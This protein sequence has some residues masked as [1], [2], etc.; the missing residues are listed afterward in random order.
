MVSYLPAKP[1]LFSLEGTP[2][3]PDY[4]ALKG[5]R[6]KCGYVFFPRQRYGCERCG[7]FGHDIE[8]IE[9]SGKGKLRAFAT[10]HRSDSENYQAPYIAATIVL[11]AGCAI[12]ALLDVADESSLFIGQTVYSTLTVVDC[13]ERGRKIAD[14]RFTPVP[15]DVEGSAGRRG[16]TS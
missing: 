14:L 16:E 3:L 2:H 9:I 13:D 1:S 12:R 11:D 5:C 8:D 7:R 4:P 10:V 6:C 15:L